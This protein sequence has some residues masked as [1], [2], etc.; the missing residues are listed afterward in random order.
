M[1]QASIL[2]PSPEESDVN[3]GLQAILRV[4]WRNRWCVGLTAV[5]SLVAASAV[6][7]LL[8]S[9]YESEATILIKEQQFSR[10]VVSPFSVEVPAERIQRMTHEV[11]SRA[12]ILES[13]DETGIFAEERAQSPDRAVELMRKSIKITPRDVSRND[14]FGAFSISFTAA[15]PE[16]AQRMTSQLSSLFVEEQS[17]G[18]ADRAEL[19]ARFFNDQLSEK[20]RKVSE[21]ARRVREF[22]ARFAS[23]LPE[24]R[25]ANQQLL[26]Q[27]RFQLDAT[28]A[29]RD[30]ARQQRAA[31]LFLFR[32][33][34]VAR[35]SKLKFDRAELLER[36]TAKYPEVLRKN[37]EI[38]DLEKLLADPGLGEGRQDKESRTV[39]FSDSSLAQ[40]EQQL[41]TSRVES[42]ALAGEQRAIEA[43][44]EEC[45]RHLSLTPA[46]E[47]ELS[48]MAREQDALNQE[49]TGLEKIDQQSELSA[50]MDKHQVGQEFRILDPPSLPS[51][52]SSP[53]RLK[54]SIA[55]LIAGL[56]LG[57]VVAYFRAKCNPTF[58]SERELIQ[59]FAAPL[60]VSV[61]L[62]VTPAENRKR[63]WLAIAGWI[64]GGLVT[65]GVFAIE[66]YVYKH[67]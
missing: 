24:A 44:I 12:K 41:E 11:L 36:F 49:I 25:A 42:E 33:T 40:I 60:V 58:C 66:Y 54:I 46:R 2:S 31:L 65:A 64:G 35:L 9:V 62:L 14:S 38:A 7:Y 17:K 28:R 13:I 18:E 19:R 53:P 48:A 3:E 20:G 45:Q 32:E 29:K 6:A 5:A 61:P 4:S 26:G 43:S 8:P 63:Q 27:L 50:D 39:A 22:K 51:T 67:P 55:A 37:N 16:L 30:Q 57:I 47:E 23:E 52:P 1:D 56:G 21:L 34:L 15:T 59:F 10:N